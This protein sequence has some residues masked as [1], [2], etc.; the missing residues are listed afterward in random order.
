MDGHECLSHKIVA[1]HLVYSQ[2]STEVL[3]F[4][5][6]VQHRPG[7]IRSLF[8]TNLFTDDVWVSLSQC[9][10]FNLLLVDTNIIVSTYEKR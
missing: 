2:C 1:L 8:R 5:Q 7:I 6:L 4:G 3:Q 10:A 9:T